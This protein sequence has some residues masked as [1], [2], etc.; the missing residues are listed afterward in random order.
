M[1]VIYMDGLLDLMTNTFI[2]KSSK[3]CDLFQLKKILHE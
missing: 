1:T 2:D 3:N